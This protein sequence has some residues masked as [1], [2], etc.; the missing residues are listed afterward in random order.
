[1]LDPQTSQASPA[2]TSETIAL[3]GGGSLERLRIDAGVIHRRLRR[4]A[5][6]SGAGGSPSVEDLDRIA[7]SVVELHRR[8]LET[9]SDAD[10]SIEDV[11]AAR[12]SIN[13]SLALVQEV[14]SEVRVG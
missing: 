12:R 13:R 7:E 8:I 4:L 1:M 3:R 14:A 9:T 10:S 5:D 2:A 11:F 6:A